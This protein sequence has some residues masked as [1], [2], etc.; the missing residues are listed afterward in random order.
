MVVNKCGHRISEL[1][2]RP[3]VHA[4]ADVNIEAIAQLPHHAP[5]LL[6]H[7]H[8]LAMPLRHLLA[9]RALLTHRPALLAHKPAATPSHPPNLA[10]G[11]SAHVPLALPHLGRIVLLRA[12]PAVVERLALLPARHGRLLHEGGA[13]R[14][15]GLER[16]DV[17]LAD[18]RA[19]RGCAMPAD[20]GELDAREGAGLGP[21][22]PAR[23]D[24]AAGRLVEDLRRRRQRDVQLR[25][26]VQVQVEVLLRRA[27]PLLAALQLALE[28]AGLL[29]RRGRDEQQGEHL[30]PAG[31]ER[32]LFAVF[33]VVGVDAWDGEEEAWVV[34]RGGRHGG[35][36]IR[37]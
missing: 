7:K 11:I 26:Q 14:Q 15:D 23:D 12:V 29:R 25:R 34:A 17:V 1:T 8:D 22:V 4:L 24:V 20:G 3:R 37:V 28:L 30:R 9:R 5:V 21:Q 18:R 6:V 33:D 19:G 2:L 13:L 16:V 27:R 36:W 10:P 32:C 31:C 35:A